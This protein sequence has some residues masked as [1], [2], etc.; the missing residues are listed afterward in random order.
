MNI[1]RERKRAILNALIK[2]YGVSEAY[3]M[4]GG[5]IGYRKPKCSICG[6][7]IYDYSEWS[8][9]GY[10]IKKCTNNCWVHTTYSLTD[11]LETKGFYYYGKLTESI[12]QSF[13]EQIK[14]NAQKMKQKNALFWRKKKTQ[15]KRKEGLNVKTI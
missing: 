5:F 7:E 14:E 6:A 12:Y 13:Q 1:Y 8:E 4:Y 10:E 2:Q 15:R 9:T 11:R 3:D